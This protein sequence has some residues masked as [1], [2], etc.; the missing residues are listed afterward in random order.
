[1]E[2]VRLFMKLGVTL[3]ACSIASG[4]GAAPLKVVTTTTDLAS[5]VRAV[6]GDRVVVK[7][8]AN[9]VEDPH[10]VEARP[11][12][13]RDLAQADVFVQNGLELETGWVPVLLKN[14]RNRAVLPGQPGFIDAST[15]IQVRHEKTGEISRALGD[16]HPAGNPHY[17][18]DPASGILVAAYIGKRLGDLQPAERV[19]FLSRSAAFQKQLANGLWGATIAEKFPAEK[20]ANLLQRGGAG[21]LHDFLKRQGL[22]AGGW[23]G[24]LRAYRGVPVIVEHNFWVYFAA[25]FDLKIVAALEPIPGVDPTT[26]HLKKVVESARADH[27]RAILALPYYPSKHAGFVSEQTGIKIAKMAHMPLARPGTEDYL[28][29]VEY[30]TGAL[31]GA[32]GK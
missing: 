31:A 24:R 25:T 28:K 6:G 26:A 1:M 13:I 20:L 17:L 8:L 3:I 23:L 32:L 5:I 4:L 16:V 19:L 27:A 30:N 15:A 18:V 10:F 14:C 12:F 9:G 22:E 29:T 21:A 2:Y 11:G 7:S